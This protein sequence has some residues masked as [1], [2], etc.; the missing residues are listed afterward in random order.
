MGLTKNC[1]FF[2][3]KFCLLCQC[4]RKSLQ[5]KLLEANKCRFVLLTCPKISKQF[6]E[7]YDGAENICEFQ[8]RCQKEIRVA[9]PH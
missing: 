9:L 6:L 1:L 3:I 7:L 8:A 5:L 4:L 2:L